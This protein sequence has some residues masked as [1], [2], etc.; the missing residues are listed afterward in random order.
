MCKFGPKYIY[1]YNFNC[2]DQGFIY[3]RKLPGLNVTPCQAAKDRA[4]AAGNPIPQKGADIH[5]CS[6]FVADNYEYDENHIYAVYEFC[7]RCKPAN[8]PVI[9]MAHLR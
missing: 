2:P 9:E 7:D 8:S 6:P 4:E 5:L 1:C 3:P